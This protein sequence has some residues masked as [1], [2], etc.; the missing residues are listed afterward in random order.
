MNIAKIIYILGIIVAIWCVLDIFKSRKL[1]LIGKILVSVL[2]LMTSWIGFA[3][4]YF[5]VRKKI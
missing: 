2:V 4:Y 3:V 1:G 5:I